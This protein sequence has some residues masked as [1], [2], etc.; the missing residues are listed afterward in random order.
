MV[1]DEAG[2]VKQV[3]DVSCTRTVMR[4]PNYDET[5]RYYR[6]ILEFPIF[7]EYTNPEARGACF[8]TR[9]WGIEILD[10]P[11]APRD[12]GRARGAFEVPDVQALHARLKPKLPD[13]PEI[14]HERWANSFI[15]TAP[16]GYR[17]KFFTRVVPAG[18]LPD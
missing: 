3:D 4:C 2:K 6:D 18:T 1:P 12:D 5:F 10:D 16:D 8:G 15:A 9:V 17:I 7:I 11:A 14:E 13:L